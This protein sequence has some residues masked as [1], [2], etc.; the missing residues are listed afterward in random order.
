MAVVA[1]RSDSEV[2][3]KGLQTRVNA[4]LLQPR[5][6]PACDGHTAV[7]MASVW[8]LWLK[9]VLDTEGGGGGLLRRTIQGET[10][11]SVTELRSCV[12]VEVAVLGFPS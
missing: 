2:V 11:Q 12:K 8:P 9:S 6:R 4:G 3:R 10:R 5:A 1:I 7:Q